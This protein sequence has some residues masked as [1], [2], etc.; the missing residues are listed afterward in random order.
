MQDKP[1]KNLRSQTD[2]GGKTTEKSGFKKNKEET[3]QAT[4]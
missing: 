1:V 4:R 2:H 3:N